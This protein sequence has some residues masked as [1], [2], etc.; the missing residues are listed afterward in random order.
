MKLEVEVDRE[1]ATL[2]LVINTHLIKKALSVYN[3]VFLNQKALS[4]MQTHE[5]QQLMDLYQ[6]YTRRIHCN[7]GVLLYIHEKYQGDPTNSKMKFP[8][9]LNA[10]PDMAELS[11]LYNKLQ[12]LYPEAVQYLKMKINQ[13]KQQQQQQQQQQQPQHLQQQQHQQ[14][15]QQQQLQQQQ[16]QQQQHHQQP[17]QK[18]PSMLGGNQGVPGSGFSGGPANYANVPSLMMGGQLDFM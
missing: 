1:R 4:Q 6:H 15:L 13:M 8:I 11:P 10:P 9:I 18:P 17:P 3:G 5:R 16:L 7:L 2:L 14:H 12:E